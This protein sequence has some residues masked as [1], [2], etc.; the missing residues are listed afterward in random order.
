[1]TCS[2]LGRCSC[3]HPT[4]TVTPT[5]SY[6]FL[7]GC[8]IDFTREPDHHATI[9]SLDAMAVDAS[10]YCLC[11]A[12]GAIDGGILW[13]KS[14]SLRHHLLDFNSPSDWLM[15]SPYLAFSSGNRRRIHPSVTA[16]TPRVPLFPNLAFGRIHRSSSAS[17][18]ASEKVQG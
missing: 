12:L 13:A 14:K 3:N 6:V 1:M 10:H 18:C 9:C 4:V 2:Q 5:R 8:M 11:H 17:N 7:Q 16:M 15:F